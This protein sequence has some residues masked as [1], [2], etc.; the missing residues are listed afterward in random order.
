MSCKNNM[1]VQVFKSKEKSLN[2]VPN[3][4]AE[5]VGKSVKLYMVVRLTVYDENIFFW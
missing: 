4:L 2:P 3:D 1:E 5:P